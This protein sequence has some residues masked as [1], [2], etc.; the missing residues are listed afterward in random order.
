MLRLL[1][2]ILLYGLT[3]LSN[4]AVVQTLDGKSFTGDIRLQS[5]DQILISPTQGAPARIPLSEILSAQFKDAAPIAAANA[6]WIGHDIGSPTVQG[7]GRFTAGNVI[8]KG[9]GAD[10]GLDRDEG[11]FVY[12]QLAGDGQITA[13]LTSLG[14]TNVLA[15]AGVMIRGSIDK[16]APSAFAMIQANERAAFRYR[17]RV[18]GVSTTLGERDN[19]FPS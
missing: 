12:Q 2:F 3:S 4:A 15:K 19:E 18:G 6:R 10:I 14:K 11:Y 8:I 7:S 17:S 16:S 9:S 1:I 13:R 5:P